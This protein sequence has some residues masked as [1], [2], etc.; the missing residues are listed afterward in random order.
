MVILALIV[1]KGR[2]IY[3]FMV[4]LNQSI[5]LPSEEYINFYYV[6]VNKRKYV[7]IC[8]KLDKME[9]VTWRGKY[10]EI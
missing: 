5:I 2:R 3:G 7:N 8:K 1:I 6:Y 10:N 4:R 9:K